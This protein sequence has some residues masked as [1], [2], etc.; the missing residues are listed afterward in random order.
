M[1]IALVYSERDNF[2][3]EIKDLMRRFETLDVTHTAV[4]K[5]R[6]TLSKEVQHTL[7]RPFS[8]HGSAR[9]F[10]TFSSCPPGGDIAAVSES[11]AE[12]QGVPSQAEHGAQC[13][14]GTGGRASAEA[15]GLR[16]CSLFH[17]NHC[18]ASPHKLKLLFLLVQVQLD[19][20]K[21]AREDAYEKYVASRFRALT[22]PNPSQSSCFY[23]QLSLSRLF[24]FLQTETST[25]RSMRRS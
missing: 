9:A 24:F 6:N 12:G 4:S 15:A 3:A 16:S 20:T 8:V 14:P 19:D 1:C 5:E 13:P 2:E 7:S 11:P 17:M 23:I 10:A 25:G 18:E 22:P 21:K